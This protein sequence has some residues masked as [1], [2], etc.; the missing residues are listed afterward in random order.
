MY[1][2][3]HP[4]VDGDRECVGVCA[5]MLIMYRGGAESECL[6]QQ[7]TPLHFNE[8]VLFIRLKRELFLPLSI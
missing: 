5:F 1:L 3:G 4:S 6:S 8:L 7:L 2:E